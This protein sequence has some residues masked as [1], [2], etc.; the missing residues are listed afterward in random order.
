MRVVDRWRGTF[1][2]IGNREHKEQEPN[3][4]PKKSRK[5]LSHQIFGGLEPLICS[6]GCFGI[7]HST[8]E[9]RSNRTSCRAKS[10]NAETIVAVGLGLIWAVDLTHD[11]DVWEGGV[12][13]A[14]W[15]KGWSRAR[16][17]VN[18]GEGGTH[19]P[20]ALI[21]FRDLESRGDATLGTPES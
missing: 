5:D 10:R 16:G 21:D 8:I 12:E 19:P 13:H 14:L 4:R 17:H 9:W 15:R 1:H 2:H 7:R 18:I 6:E 20:L 3:S 11:F